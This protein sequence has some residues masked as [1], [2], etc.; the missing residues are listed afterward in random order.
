MKRFYISIILLTSYFFLPA[1]RAQVGDYRNRFAV[2][3]SGGYALNSVSF[4]PDVQQTMHGGI[5]AGI[6]ARYTCEKYFTTICSVQAEVNITQLGWEQKIEDLDG[7][8]VINAAT[9]QPEQYKRDITYVQIPLMAHL[10]WGRE[11][12]GMNFFID[13][14]PQMAFCTGDKTTR[15]Y[16]TPSPARA[17]SVVAQE[18]MPVENKFDYG[19]IFGAGVEYDIRHV[20]RFS[21][22]ARYYYGLGNLYGDAKTDEFGCSN[23]NT[24]FIKAAYM[25]DL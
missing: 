1:C 23:H 9:M 20:G 6:A 16:D 25:H 21:I 10:A 12:H 17:S 22:G 24:I 15:N 18:T 11:Q 7:Q 19:I 14:G 3:A 13:L 5:T 2:G 4:Q 8:P